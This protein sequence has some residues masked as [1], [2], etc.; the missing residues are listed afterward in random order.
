[1][2]KCKIESKIS[3]LEC[4]IESLKKELRDCD[5]ITETL[6][7]EFD[8]CTGHLVCVEKSERFC[9]GKQGYDITIGL[10]GGEIFTFESMTK[11]LRRHKLEIVGLTY[12]CERLKITVAHI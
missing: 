3:E 6:M 8:V 11:T 10:S 2:D 1:M 4:S 9:G 12:K 7:N 5:D